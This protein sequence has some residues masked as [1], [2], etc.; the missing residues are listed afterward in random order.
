MN[1]ERDLH[2]DRHPTH[3]MPLRPENIRRQGRYNLLLKGL[4]VTSV[5]VM[6]VLLAI[7]YRNLMGYV[8]QNQEILH[9]H[10]VLRDLDEV[11]SIVKD[12]ETGTRGFMLSN[13]TTYLEPYKSAKAT[14]SPHLA[15][16]SELLAPDT[17]SGSGLAILRSRIELRMQY[18]EQRVRDQRWG[19]VPL[20][21]PDS[22]LFRLG[23]QSMDQL[24]IAHR[25]LVDRYTERL[26]AQEAKGR[27]LV[28]TGPGMVAVYAGVSVL[29]I[30]VL[31]WW[32]FRALVRAQHAERKALRTAAELDREARTR[33]LAE[34][35]L[36]RVLDSS[37]SG[38]MAFRAIRDEQGRIV[39]FE[40]TR[41]NEAAET[42]VHKKAE[43]MLHRSILDVNPEN[44][45]SVLFN[46]YIRLVETGEPL[47]TET[48][49][50]RDGQTTTL[51]VSAVR[52]LDGMVVTFTDI[53]EAK[54]QAILVA[55]G[56]RLTVTGRF[57]RMV[58]H[59]V[60]NPLTNIQL[61][62]DQLESEGT[63]LPEQ[64]IYLDILRRNSHRIGQL[65]T[66]MLHT[67]RPLEMKMEQGSLNEVLADAYARVKDRCELRK[68]KAEL[69]LD[70][71]LG[72]VPIDR[73]TLTVA[74]TNLLVNAVEAM[75]EGN[76]R[77]EIRSERVKDRVRVT[78][79]DNGKGMSAEDRERIF[80]PFFSGRKGGMGLGLT[81]ARN[82]FNA[83][84]VLLSVDSELGKGTT[85][86]LLFPA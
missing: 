32:M 26:T 70:P 44:K 15:E 17:G 7:T 84:G 25:S 72:T 69:R 79:H 71:S 38:I 3:R 66:E 5:L 51:A 45:A 9:S 64:Q 2:V 24:R 53:T 42:I 13:D 60:R 19:A 50:T 31:L 62:L 56:E 48:E 12:A 75:E 68:A 81:E 47:K 14:L 86:T 83:H 40:C 52:L 23:K 1:T 61:A 77:L 55:E 74:F 39:D 22:I 4:A 59:E 73:S 27:D 28:F 30:G 8:R 78:I 36:K 21:R 54:R 85:F 33:E 11:L 10:K 37:Q 57:A 46:Q 20:G 76:G 58:G 29:C 35:S 65:I 49:Y 67:S 6:L 43:E 16:L 41:M 34:R 80:Q 82:I 18:L 63:Q